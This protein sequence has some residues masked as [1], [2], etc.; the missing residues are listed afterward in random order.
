MTI[1]FAIGA[2]VAASL[3]NAATK[4]DVKTQTKNVDLAGAM[5]VRPF[6]TG[7][8][9]PLRCQPGEMFFKT[10]ATPGAN[11][12]GCT[13]TDT[14]T[15]QGQSTSA[16]GGTATGAPLQVT[17][18]DNTE[19]VVGSDCTPTAV[20]NVRIGSRVYSFTSAATATLS[21][22]QGTVYV[23]VA[24][25]GS[26]VVGAAQADSPAVVCTRCRAEDP[27]V[28]F[29]ADSIPLAFWHATA[30]VWDLAGTDT[31]AVLSTARTFTAGPNITIT[32]S[33]TNVTIAADS[34]TGS[35]SELQYRKDGKLGAV[36]SSSV[37]AG[38]VRIG[39]TIPA[40]DA[41]LTIGDPI[42]LGHASGTA[43]AINA[44]ADFA[45][46]LANWMIGG[47]SLVSVTAAG[48]V[49]LRGS[50][51]LNSSELRLSADGAEAQLIGNA[52][53][54]AGSS[55]RLGVAGVDASNQVRVGAGAS[56]TASLVVNG[57]GKVSMG[58]LAP[59]PSATASGPDLIVQDSTS[60]T[61][62]TQVVISA[63]AAQDRPLTQ[64]T[65][66]NGTA[67]ARISAD[68]ALQNLPWG[69]KPVCAAGVRGMFWHEQGAD[70][71]KDAVEVCAKDAA[72]VYAWRALF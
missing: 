71:I 72:D 7:A 51:L 55:V 52:A 44:P 63:G 16:G 4:I 62:S 70:G 8:V 58:T 25:D 24:G 54:S 17:R 31:R 28:S 15:V 42:A 38:A 56:G 37:S 3:L 49:M 2:A 43:F 20:C 45:G 1:K 36:L 21:S 69:S 59:P 35:G 53:S 32:E 30:G 66:A 40:G 19:L 9:L 14:W 23:Y 47:T 65:A 22:G 33:G 46:D 13:A 5:S 67:G 48:D 6:R 50:A 57:L 26:I 27:V 68:G 11:S 10:D 61:G 39:A 34:A 29:P 41:L 60:A 18:T 12:Y 64:W